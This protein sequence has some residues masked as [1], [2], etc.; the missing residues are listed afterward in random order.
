MDFSPGKGGPVWRFFWSL[1]LIQ[2]IYD[3]DITQLHS[4]MVL[5]CFGPLICSWSMS[6]PVFKSKLSPTCFAVWQRFEQALVTGA[7]C[8]SIGNE[9]TTSRKHGSWTFLQCGKLH[10]YKPSRIFV[11]PD[12]LHVPNHQVILHIITNRCVISVIMQRPFPWR[13]TTRWNLVALD[14]SIELRASPCKAQ[15]CEAMRRI[16][17]RPSLSILNQPTNGG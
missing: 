17:Y 6:V 9:V 13:T 11:L 15:S 7:K 12:L 2:I 3:L 8:N 5:V 14:L 16:P 4:T 10:V 1:K